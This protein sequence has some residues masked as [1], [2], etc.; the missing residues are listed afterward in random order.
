MAPPNGQVAA[1]ASGA[2]IVKSRSSSTSSSSKCSSVE[3]DNFYRATIFALARSL[4]QI[5]RVEWA[6]VRDPLFS[7]CPRPPKD[8]ADG[9]VLSERQQDAVLAL[10]VFF[11]ES[12]GQCR[13]EV[14]P[15]LLKLNAALFGATVQERREA[16]ESESVRTWTSSLQ[17]QVLIFHLF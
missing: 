15:Y 2:G 12:G 8:A 13:D 17:S 14:L 11:L 3:D 7:S 1:R 6:L 16:R 4:S 9:W 10:G 5:P